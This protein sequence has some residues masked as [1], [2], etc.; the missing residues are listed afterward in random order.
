MF[1]RT[2][3]AH[4][5][6]TC[7]VVHTREP[8]MGI[9][10]FGNRLESVRGKMPQKDFAA[11]FGVGINTLFRY[12]KGENHPNAAFISSVCEKFNLSANWLLFGEGEKYKEGA[13]AQ[14]HALD[15]PESP[16]SN[17]IYIDENGLVAIPSLRNPDIEDFY[18]LPLVET[19]LSA[20][21]GSFVLSEAVETYYAFRRNFINRIATH[22]KNVVL[23]CATGNSM[24][25][26]IFDG[27]TIMID[28][29]RRSIEDG[30]IFAM[31]FGETIAVKRLSLLPSDKVMVISDNKDE[32]APYEAYIKDI[33]V[34]GK[35][36]ISSHIHV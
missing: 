17:T 21:A 26:T 6:E 10:G 36:L 15:E 14:Q 34:I 20:G 18:F 22:Y 30:Q 29:G 27:D 28:T 11:I 4:H 19:R 24:E 35:L 23:A 12:E 33:H 2:T 3:S 32:Y 25:R 13:A 9:E 8:K 5:F 1:L 16:E 7:E 31:R